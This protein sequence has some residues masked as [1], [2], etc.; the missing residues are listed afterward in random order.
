M[1][2]IEK[3]KFNVDS[4]VV[5]EAVPDTI[6]ISFDGNSQNYNLK[7]LDKF[8]KITITRCIITADNLPINF[9][10]TEEL[11]LFGCEIDAETIR[12]FNGIKIIVLNN[13]TI[14]EKSNVSSNYDYSDVAIRLL[15]DECQTVIIH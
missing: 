4:N 6:Y 1:L 12:R 13:C 5:V 11:V 8:R 7:N 14:T 15:L 2:N 10:N 3:A 9:K